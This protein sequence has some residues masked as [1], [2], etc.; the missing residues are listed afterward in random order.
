MQDLMM[1]ATGGTTDPNTWLQV[2]NLGGAGALAW[3]LL[4]KVMPEHKKEIKEEI[5]GVK[6]SVDGVKDSLDKSNDRLFS[7]L[8]SQV[9]K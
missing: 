3:Y 4:F 9:N 5:Q 8:E 2:V 7:L 1:F 6:N